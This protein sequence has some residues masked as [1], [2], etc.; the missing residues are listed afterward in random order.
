MGCATSPHIAYDIGGSYERFEAVAGTTDDSYDSIDLL[1]KVTLDNNPPI[2]RLISVGHPEQ[3]SIDVTG[4]SRLRL[5]V[6]RP[7]APTCFRQSI[8]AVWGD[9]RLLT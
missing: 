4:V 6:E 8:E 3:F 7:F 2:S 1:M 5:E 9:A